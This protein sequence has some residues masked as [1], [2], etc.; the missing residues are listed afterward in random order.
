[1]SVKI[2]STELHRILAITPD[3]HNIMLVGKHGIGKSQIIERYFVR[4]GKKVVTL[5]LGQM[6]DP[7]DL[8]GLPVLDGVKT[9]FRPPWWFPE[10]AISIRS[11]HSQRCLK[12]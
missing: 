12:R 1:M 11:F 7:G 4:L 3:H 5:F 9:D 8:I 10:V 6:S 2:N